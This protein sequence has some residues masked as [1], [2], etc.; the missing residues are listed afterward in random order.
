[1]PAVIDKKRELFAGSAVN[2]SLPGGAA[3]LNEVF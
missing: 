1:M 2:T 3:R